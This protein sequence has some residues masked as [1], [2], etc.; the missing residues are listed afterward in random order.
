MESHLHGIH[1]VLGIKMQVT[2]GEDRIGTGHRSNIVFDGTSEVG[3]VMPL[4][5][6][7]AD[8][9]R[10]VINICVDFKICSGDTDEKR[11]SFL[12]DKGIGSFAPRSKIH[13]N[14]SIP[15]TVCLKIS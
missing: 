8:D 2:S 4:N 5:N 6:T 11:I 15:L 13:A 10:C 7:G 14:L 3:C 9:N 12:I 1:E